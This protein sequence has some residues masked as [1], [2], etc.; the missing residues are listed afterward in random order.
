MTDR[1]NDY[2]E[3][4]P[5]YSVIA[6]FLDGEAVDSS[7]LKHA[8][9]TPEGLDYL[10]D[11]LALR[12]SVRSTFP[13]EATAHRGRP[14]FSRSRSISIAAAMVL[15]ALSGYLVGQRFDPVGRP[16]QVS[17]SPVMIEFNQPTAVPVPTRVIQLQPGVNWKDTSGG[18]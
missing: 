12:E 7:G 1:E 18:D 10:V 6:S 4:D 15:A 2:G 13:S 16:A 8:L 17:E 9:A 11:L 5:V 3:P 14:W